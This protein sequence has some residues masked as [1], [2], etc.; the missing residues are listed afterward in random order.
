[1]KHST[2]F[3]ALQRAENSS[4]GFAW[5]NTYE[6]QGFSALQRAENSSIDGNVVVSQVLRSF[7]ALQRAENSSIRIQEAR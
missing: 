2:C 4:I 6:V 5:A 3:S 7:S 1:M